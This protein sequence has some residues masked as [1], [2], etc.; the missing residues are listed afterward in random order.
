MFKGKTTKS[1]AM[2]GLIAAAYVV[3]TY[4]FQPISYGPIQLRVSEI[5]TILPAITK[6]AIPGL[7]VGCIIS[8]LSSPFGLVDIILGTSATLIASILTYY[9]RKITFKG[10]P[11]LG[12]LF[13]VLANALIVGAEITFF[14]P[15]GAGTFAAYAISALQI[16]IGE[17][18]VCYGFGIPFFVAFKKFLVK[19]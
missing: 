7:M 8:N 13:P 14:V 12:P 19:K 2:S 10:V 15:S 11:I 16:G 18:I 17:L 4:V 1:L 5:F 9:T 6:T 3:L